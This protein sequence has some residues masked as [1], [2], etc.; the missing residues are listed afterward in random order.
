MQAGRFK[1]MIIKGSGFLTILFFV[2]FPVAIFVEFILDYTGIDTIPYTLG[3]IGH[4]LAYLFSGYVVFAIYMAF[5]A[6]IFLVFPAEAKETDKLLAT[7][8]I[9]LIIVYLISHAGI[10]LYSPFFRHERTAR[11]IYSALYGCYFMVVF[12]GIRKILSKPRQQDAV[13][14]R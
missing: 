6:L 5:F 1:N 10:V 13:E 2:N 4:G 8:I 12:I 3:G 7:F 9:P 11:L 14:T